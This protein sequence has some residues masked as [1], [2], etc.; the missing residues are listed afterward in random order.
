MG[1]VSIFA[2]ILYINQFVH[3]FS[4]ML[5]MWYKNLARQE[6]MFDNVEDLW[7]GD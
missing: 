4:S 5:Y 1:I 2:R 3:F 7:N 6:L